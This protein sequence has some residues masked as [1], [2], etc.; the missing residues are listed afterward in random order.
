MITKQELDQ[1][2]GNAEVGKKLRL[3]FPKS[4]LKLSPIQ[5]RSFLALN[6]AGVIEGSLG[7]SVSVLGAIRGDG[8]GGSHIFVVTNGPSFQNF[9][10][11]SFEMIMLGCLEK[12][13]VAS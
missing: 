5:L 12:I 6:T 7:F 1:A 9:S 4:S 11:Q 3:T 10:R 8:W 13:E 2:L